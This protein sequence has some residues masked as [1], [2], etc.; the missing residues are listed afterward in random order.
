MAITVP[1]TSF[2]LSLPQLLPY[3][4]SHFHLLLSPSPYPF[5]FVSIRSFR[6][7]PDF[8]FAY[9]SF[10]P[11]HFLKQCANMR[12]SVHWHQEVKNVFCFFNLRMDFFPHLRITS[13][14][15]L[16][17]CFLIFP[18]CLYPL[19]TY[20]FIWRKKFSRSSSPCLRIYVLLKSTDHWTAS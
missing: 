5:A 2:L 7:L 17:F 6:F 12:E 11:F 10:L 15:F 8:P 13:F 16:S 9:V 3:P 19:Y 14:F 20:R 4:R 1:W 18:Q